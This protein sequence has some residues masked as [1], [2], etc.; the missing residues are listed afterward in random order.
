MVKLYSHR[1]IE[2][3]RGPVAAPDA[4]EHSCKTNPIPGP[5]GRGEAGGARGGSDCAKRTQ[6]PRASRNGRRPGTPEAQQPPGVDRATSPRCPASGN[7][8]NLERTQMEANALQSKGLGR[9]CA[10]GRPCETNPIC[11]AI[12]DQRTDNRPP[13][14]CP[15][16]QQRPA[17]CAKRNPILGCPGA[18][19]ICTNKA[20]FAGSVGSGKCFPEKELSRIG[21][22][23]GGGETNPIS[24]A[25]A[26]GAG[27]WA[28]LGAGAPK[29][30][31]A[32]L[33]RRRIVAG[34]MVRGVFSGK[35]GANDHSPVQGDWI[36][37]YR[38]GTV[39]CDGRRPG[40]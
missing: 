15:L 2:I 28:W 29:T 36:S 38:F 5:D 24:R 34:E 6:F 40:R 31:D 17:D 23:K 9:F 25:E 19:P 27:G 7:K 22:P 35:V 32:W 13:S 26:V 1:D 16:E 18:A 33:R 4:Q 37:A 14:P 8:A 21:R 39:Q 12:R 10:E 3:A 20:N 30:V 11:A